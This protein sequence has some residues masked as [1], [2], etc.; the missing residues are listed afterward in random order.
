MHESSQTLLQCDICVRYVIVV[1]FLSK[2]KIHV[3]IKVK[4]DDK[5][6][7]RM[8]LNS[9]HLECLVYHIYFHIKATELKLYHVY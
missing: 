6:G 5:Y 9:K 4:T 7:F 3:C 8:E 1:I 2:S